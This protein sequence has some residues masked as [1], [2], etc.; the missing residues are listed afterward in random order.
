[1][2]G[3]AMA[4][5]LWAGDAPD[6]QATDAGPASGL[7]VWDPRGSGHLLHCPA[8]QVSPAKKVFLKVV[9]SM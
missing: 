6:L 7:G 3:G 8:K 9:R 2:A 5:L 4:G 1:M